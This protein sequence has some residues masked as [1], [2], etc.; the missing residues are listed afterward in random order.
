VSAGDAALLPV[1]DVLRERAGLVFGDSRRDVALTAVRRAMEAAG[2]DDAAAYLARVRRGGA[3]LDAL[4]ADATVGETYFFRHPEQWEVVRR[5]ALPEIVSRRGDRPLRGWSAACSTGEEAY[6]LS[7]VCQEEGIGAERRSIV[8]TDISR[9]R[10]EAARAAR[11]GRWALRDVPAAT[12]EAHF[13]RRGEEWRLNPDVREGVEFRALNLVED[14]WPSPASGIGEMDLIF[15]RNMLIYLD[16]PSVRRVAERLIAALSDDGW[17]FPGPS[18]PP[19][20]DYVRCEVIVT[21]AGLV[22]RKRAP[23]LRSSSRPPAPAAS[24]EPASRATWT[25][26]ASPAAPIEANRPL[27]PSSAP[28]RAPTSDARLSVAPPVPAVDGRTTNG[29]GDADGDPGRLYAAR[30]YERAAA[31]AGGRIARGMANEA[32]WIV[33]VRALA[34]RGRLA[35][36]EA[37]CATALERYR[38]SAELHD[39]HALLLSGAGRT[40]EAAAAL[41]QALYLDPGLVVAHVRMAEVQARLGNANAA[42]RSLR[43]AE[44]LLAALPPDAE[45]PA[46]DAMPAAHLLR[47]VRARLAMLPEGAS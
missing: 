16:R 22:Y 40:R 1:L 45:V 10:L 20:A 44:S 36:A 11:Y 33:R 3:A 6:T 39:V 47:T 46:S 29:G 17:L 26:S 4:L 24:T 5:Q 15:C 12:V 42:R 25:D 21:P 37:A 14:D 19:L 31:A 9:P 32:T 23:A 41:R 2:T 8:G 28:P 18:D 27:A 35:E 34:N 30:D 7:I 43:N 38:A 13:T